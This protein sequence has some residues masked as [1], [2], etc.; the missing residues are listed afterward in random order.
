MC[1]YV[2]AR[3]R[4]WA[5]ACLGIGIIAPKAPGA[6]F[7]RCWLVF[8]ILLKN[9]WRN[10]SELCERRIFKPRQGCMPMRCHSLIPLEICARPNHCCHGAQIR[11]I[12]VMRPRHMGHIDK[13]GAHFSH[14]HRWP[15]SS[16]AI[17]AAACMHTTHSLTHS[18]THSFLVCVL[19][20]AGTPAPP[21][22]AMA[23]SSGPRAP[24]W[25][26]ALGDSFG[27]A[28]SG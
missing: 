10:E 9:F 19:A 27:A 4:A 28:A 16:I 21:F 2:C 14:A 17:T 26:L 1:V 20:A 13:S 23:H 5:N 24:S 8:S 15:Q 3:V 11:L 7:S 12:S 25:E 22:S 6:L 18:L